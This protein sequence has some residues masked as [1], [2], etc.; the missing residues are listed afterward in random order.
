MAT[1]T[2]RNTTPATASA[3]AGTRTRSV[4]RVRAAAVAAAVAVSTV[5]YLAASAAGV[6][7]LLTDPGKK[8]AYHLKAFDV[9]LF[10]TVSALLGWATMAVLERFTRHA[11]TVWSVLAGAVLALSFVPIFLEQATASTRAVLVVLHIVVAVALLP[12]LR[13]RANR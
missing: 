7:F 1:T 5:L 3:T 4:R 12:L 6:D 2:I 10:S 9:A 8:E 11:R 13:R